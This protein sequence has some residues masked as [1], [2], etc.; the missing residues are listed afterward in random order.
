EIHAAAGDE[1]SRRTGVERWAG[2]RESGKRDVHLHGTGVFPATAGGGA[3][4]VPSVREFNQRVEEVDSSSRKATRLAPLSGHIPTDHGEVWLTAH[5]QECLCY[6]RN[7]RAMLAARRS[8]DDMNAVSHFGVPR[9]LRIP[10]L[11]MLVA[12]LLLAGAVPAC[13]QKDKK[14]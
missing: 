12:A 4:G 3:G 10:A 5:K 14:K 13:A 6:W 8:F 2:V 11:A 9:M 1:R 7:A